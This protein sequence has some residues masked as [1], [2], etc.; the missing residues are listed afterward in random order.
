MLHFLVNA[1]KNLLCVLHDR[2]KPA[3]LILPL[4]DDFVQLLVKFLPSALSVGH[5]FL[6]SL[7]ISRPEVYRHKT[8]N[9]PFLILS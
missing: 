9:I 7:K 3:R 6:P 8:D 2:K 4:Q 1:A 5:V